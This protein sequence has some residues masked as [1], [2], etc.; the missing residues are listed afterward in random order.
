[1]EFIFKNKQNNI[2]LNKSSLDKYTEKQKKKK[3]ILL[4]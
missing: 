4:K 2:F 1:M 3:S